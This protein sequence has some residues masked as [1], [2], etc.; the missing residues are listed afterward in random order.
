MAH[1][2]RRAAAGAQALG[3]EPARAQVE[4]GLGLVEHEQVGIRG[5]R[6]RQ[7]D[8]PP[9]PARELAHAPRLGHA[10]QPE[11]AEQVGDQRAVGL[12]GG[13]ERRQRVVVGALELAQAVAAR[14][15]PSAS[16]PARR[17]SSSSAGER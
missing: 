14:A 16:S 17:S 11:L 5:Q 8:Q 7:Q 9:L 13:R 2:H 4:M 12:L 1:E 6:P 3:D 15:P 10:A